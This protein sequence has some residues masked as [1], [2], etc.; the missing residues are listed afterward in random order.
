MARM[1]GSVNLAKNL[2]VKS[3]PSLNLKIKADEAPRLLCTFL[4]NVTGT[5]LKTTNLGPSVRFI[6]SFEAIDLVTGETARG[7]SMYL[8]GHAETVVA[9]AFTSANGRPIQF[10]LN[11]GIRYRRIANEDGSEYT[12]SE[13]G[14]I[15]EHDPLASLKAAFGIQSIAA[16]QAPLA[17]EAPVAETPS[18]HSDDAGYAGHDETL[19]D[20]DAEAQAEAQAAAD[21]QA[22]KKGGKKG[23]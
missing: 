23:K 16:K 6:G 13:I 12:V 22:A 21:V 7:T 10:A 1:Q 4:G 8:P 11:V 2:T 20:P 5:E 18:L 17:L 9:D 19:V 14:G 3:L 15:T